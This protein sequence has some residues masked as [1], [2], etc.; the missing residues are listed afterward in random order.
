MPSPGA[1]GAV[2]CKQRVLH[3]T[4]H[5]SYSSDVKRP[6]IFF[7]GALHGNERVGPT[8]TV[9]LAAL[10]LKAVECH[11]G[12]DDFISETCKYPGLVENLELVPWLSWLVHNRSIVLIPMANAKGYYYDVRTENGLDPNRDFPYHNFPETCMRT[13]AGRTINEVFRDH[14]FQISVTFHGGV[15]SV[16]Y[17]WGDMEHQYDYTCP[18]DSVVHEVAKQVSEYAGNS[19][20]LGIQSYRIGSM[21]SALYPVR[22]GMEDWAYAGSWDT[23][24]KD[25]ITCSPDTFGGYDSSKMTYED[26]TLRAFNYL[27]ETSDDK[28]PAPEMLGYPGHVL[29]ILN[30]SDNGHI[31]RNIRLA[32]LLTDVVEPYVVW[33]SEFENSPSTTVFQ[34]KKLTYTWEVG[35]AFTI[36]ASRLLV[37]PWPSHISDFSI[38]D[39]NIFLESVD[40]ATVNQTSTNSPPQRVSFQEELVLSTP[41]DYFVLPVAVVDQGWLTTADGASPPYPP[42]THLANAR[43]NLLWNKDVVSGR[44][45]KGNVQWVG[46]AYMVHVKQNYTRIVVIGFGVALSTLLLI[47]LFIFFRSRKSCQMGKWPPND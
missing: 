28:T 44:R 34:G 30:P 17:E 43:T 1:C 27:V 23:S 3:I 33:S 14:I 20:T 10:L 36:D 22:G 45:V 37:G 32:L 29:N 31:T 39:L 12:G 4:D 47:F 40:F 46:P 2:A 38:A 41:G 11:A 15:E 5:N 21:N 19:E 9:E 6:E 35:G 42:Q 7:S 13:I 8:V 25:Q 16:S 26:A 24:I 18:D